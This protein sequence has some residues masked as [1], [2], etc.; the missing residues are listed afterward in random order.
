MNLNS[1][2]QCLHLLLGKKLDS[3]QRGSTIVYVVNINF[4][5]TD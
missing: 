3:L 5:I 4:R 1:I 2:V